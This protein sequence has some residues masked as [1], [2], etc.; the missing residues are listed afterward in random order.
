[1]T[2]VESAIIDPFSDP[3]AWDVIVVA[4]VE[5]PGIIEVDGIEGF[6]RE[7]GWDKKKGKGSQGATS[8]LTTEP[9]AE[10]KITFTLWEPRH[11]REWAEF[12]PLLR[13]T[14]DKSKTQAIAIYH[15]SLTDIGLTSVVVQKIGP[16][17]HK[18]KGK[19]KRVIEFLEF[20]PPPKVSIV[21]TPTRATEVTKSTTAGDPPDPIADR[22]QAEIALLLKQAAAP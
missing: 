15:P 11:W 8:T 12:I 22:Q 5:S 19:Y 10:G 1:M 13:Y 3:H 17:R 16:I 2:A 9:P 14:P 6:D 4:G 18:G 7:T 21:A 20:R